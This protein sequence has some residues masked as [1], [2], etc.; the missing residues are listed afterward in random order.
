MTPPFLP[1]ASSLFFL[2]YP[3]DASRHCLKKGQRGEGRGEKENKREEGVFA[4]F[5]E[6]SALLPL[7]RRTNTRE[8]ARRKKEKGKEEKKK[9]RIINTLYFHRFENGRGGEGG[10]GGEDPSSL[11][12]DKSG[13]KGKVG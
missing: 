11:R 6:S 8:E 4:D 5:S 9:S 13:E 1:L 12:S 2:P 10:E 3:G 7:T